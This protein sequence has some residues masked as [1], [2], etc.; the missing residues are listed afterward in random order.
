MVHIVVNVY[1]DELKIGLKLEKE[2]TYSL[3]PILSAKETK[4]P[5]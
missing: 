3:I 4:I 1:I 2:V 5:K